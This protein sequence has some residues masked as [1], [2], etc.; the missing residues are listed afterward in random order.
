MAIATVPDHRAPGLPDVPYSAFC[1][2]CWYPVYIL[3]IE[4]EN[5]HGACMDGKASA[6]ECQEA[7]SRARF[8]ASLHAAKT[9]LTQEKGNG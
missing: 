3:W 5:H 9:T 4:P 2:V 6:T 1:Q 8:A 7:M